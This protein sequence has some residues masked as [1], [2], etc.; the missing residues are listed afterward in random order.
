MEAGRADRRLLSTVSVLFFLSGATALAYEA[1]WFKRLSQVWGSSALALASVVACFLAGIGIGAWLGGRVADRL[2]RPLLAYA[3]CEV[4]IG[5]L[6]L[7]VPREIFWLNGVS[8][9]A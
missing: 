3:V 2:R 4:G 1:M 9:A 6:A 7:A 5:L 8:A